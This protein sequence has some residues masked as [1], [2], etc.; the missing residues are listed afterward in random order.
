ME[1][2]GCLIDAVHIPRAIAA[3]GRWSSPA[4]FWKTLRFLE[5]QLSD[6]QRHHLEG[7]MR[8]F[9]IVALVAI[10]FARSVNATPGTAAGAFVFGVGAA[11]GCDHLVRSYM[12]DTPESDEPW[13]LVWYHVGTEDVAGFAAGS[14]CAIPAGAI[15]AVVGFAVEAAVISTVPVIG[16]STAIGASGLAVTGARTLAAARAAGTRVTEAATRRAAPHV[17]AAEQWLGKIK[18]GPVAASTPLR[19][20]FME[21]LYAKQKGMDAVCRKIPLPPLYVGPWWDRRLNPAIHV[22]HKKPRAKG[23]SDSEGNL[24]LTAAEFNLKKGALTGN[25]LRAAKRSFCPA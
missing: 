22:D 6:R 21:P 2:E 19:T 8:T 25:E 13:Y 18:F 20:K 23:G 5:E 14:A 24:Q 3:E 12:E 17:Q 1:K 15:G 10:V 7:R 9:L 16:A 4:R 11:V